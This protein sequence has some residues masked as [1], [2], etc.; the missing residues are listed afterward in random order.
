MIENTPGVPANELAVDF[1]SLFETMKVS[2]FS[3]GWSAKSVATYLQ[4]S[5]ILKLNSREAKE[6]MLRV[7]QENKVPLEDILSDAVNRDKALDAYEEFALK[8]LQERTS[9][10]KQETVQ[11]EKE[12]ADREKRIRSMKDLQTQDE[13]AYQDWL[14]KKI[15]Q[16]EQLV[17]VVSLITTEE[18]ISVGSIN[19]RKTK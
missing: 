15:A 13:K 4:S 14:K 9:K 1:D 11:L 3:H 18:K 12:I 7:L 16:E 10:R 8:K 2:S 17:K 5:D 19:S 6:A